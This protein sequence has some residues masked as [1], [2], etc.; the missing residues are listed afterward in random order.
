METKL[1]VR[2]EAL[3]ERCEICHQSDLFNPQTGQCERCNK[4]TVDNIPN[5]TLVNKK[6]SRRVRLRRRAIGGDIA[7]ALVLA[8]GSLEYLKDIIDNPGLIILVVIAFFIFLTRL[9]RK[10]RL[11][12]KRLL[13]TGIRIEAK[14][15]RFIPGESSEIVIS[16]SFG[17]TEY[18]KRTWFIREIAVGQPIIIYVDPKDPTSFVF[19]EF[20]SYE[21]AK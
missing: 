9:F 14:V 12:D 16:Y 19:E 1:I 11:K 15:R 6:L 18:E 4:N 2:A 13:E 3:P 21:I 7:F 17:S 5:N 10:F 20:S 8:L